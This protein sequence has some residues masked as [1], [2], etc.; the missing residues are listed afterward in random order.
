MLRGYLDKLAAHLDTRG[1]GWLILSDF[2]EHLGL[3]AREE[4]LSWIEAGGLRVVGRID[5]RPK[6]GK[7]TDTSDPLHAARSAEVTSLWRLAKK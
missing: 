4:L 7:A 1:E 5:T 6:H 3:R 2:A